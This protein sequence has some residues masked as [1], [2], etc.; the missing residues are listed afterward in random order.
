MYAVLVEENVGVPVRTPVAV[1]NI[2]P[3]GTEGV[4]ANVLVPT[5]PVA[6]TSVD[7]AMLIDCVNV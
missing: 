1:L 7:D 4:I 2:N 6:V 5:P 3:A